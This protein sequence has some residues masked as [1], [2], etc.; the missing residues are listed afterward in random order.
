MVPK[1]DITASRPCRGFRYINATRT[2]DRYP[3][4][5]IHDFTMSLKETQCFTKLDLIKA[6]YQIPVEEED[7]PKTDMTIPFGLFEL[8]RMPF[9]LRNT[10]TIFATIN[11]RSFTWPTFYFRIHR[12]CLN[13][14]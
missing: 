9:D 4:P 14:E 11:R 2:A 3:I 13:C 6:Y 5:H 1:P 12:R 7:I 10:S 8:L